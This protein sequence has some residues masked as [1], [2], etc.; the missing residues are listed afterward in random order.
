ME[1]SQRVVNDAPISN[2]YRPEVS[3]AQTYFLQ[4]YSVR[5]LLLLLLL[6]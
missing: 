1:V 4:A 6:W 3:G 5:L 2:I